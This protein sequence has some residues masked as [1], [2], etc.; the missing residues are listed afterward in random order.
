MTRSGDTDVSL[1]TEDSDGLDGRKRGPRHG[2]N[3][4]ANETRKTG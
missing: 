4:R 2:T 1:S 3:G